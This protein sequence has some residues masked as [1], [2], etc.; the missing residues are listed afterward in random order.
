MDER[1][2]ASFEFKI[3][4]YIPNSGLWLGISNYS[5]LCQEPDCTKLTGSHQLSVHI[6]ITHLF[7]GRTMNNGETLVRWNA[8]LC[9]LD[10]QPQ[11]Y[12]DTGDHVTGLLSDGFP[13][14]CEPLFPSGMYI[15][16]S[17]M[18]IRRIV[19]SRS[20]RL[21]VIGRYID[22]SPITGLWMFVMGDSGGP[23]PCTS[24][25]GVNVGNFTMCRY[26]CITDGFV[27]YTVL[28]ISDR[29]AIPTLD[30]AVIC[31]ITLV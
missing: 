9:N 15:A 7:S 11:I 19:P 12:Q 28:G 21:N 8:N 18:F 22:C 10:A 17:V 30:T 14:T 31:D 20:L 5:I 27:N 1:Y 23:R 25:I 16:T 26:Q 6:N 4:M 29:H 2:F 3:C 24:Y 13:Q